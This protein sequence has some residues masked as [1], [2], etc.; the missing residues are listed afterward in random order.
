MLTSCPGS[1]TNHP[2]PRAGAG[3]GGH[4]GHARAVGG[5]LRRGN[6]AG[7]G[8]GPHPER[9][10]GARRRGAVGVDAAHRRRGPGA[11]WT[12]PRP[13]SAPRPI[14]CRATCA[15]RLRLAAERIRAFH[16]LQPVQ[17]WTTDTLGGRLGQRVTPLR[18]VGVYVPGGSAPLPS[19]L[20]MS[21]I[22]AQVA[23]VAEIVVVTPPGRDGRVPPVILAAAE[24]IGLSDGSTPWAGRRPSPP[25]PTARP[26][27]RA[28]TRSSGRATC[29]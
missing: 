6:R 5:H 19:S 1:P 15:T 12:W 26:P 22:P 7:G 28:W 10:A 18:R 11:A 2:A 3:A 8:R 4:A 17:S 27:S 24:A 20:L 25:W 13:T 14:R 29:S 16:A 21:A 9:R 23:G